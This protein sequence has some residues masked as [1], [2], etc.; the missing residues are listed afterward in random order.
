MELLR[1]WIY[2]AWF[3]L[4]LGWWKLRHSARDRAL[5]MIR[6]GVYY[7]LEMAHTI[8]RAKQGAMYAFGDSGIA[9][10]LDEII[11]KDVKARKRDS[12]E[13][14][15]DERL[16]FMVDGEVVTCPVE[17]TGMPMEDTEL[18]DFNRGDAVHQAMQSIQ[19]PAHGFAGN[20]KL[21][22]A[23][24]AIVII[25]FVI[26]KFVLHGHIPG[27]GVAPTPTPTPIPT[28]TPPSFVPVVAQWLN[29]FAMNV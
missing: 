28:P 7:D 19:G 10:A 25:G 29:W 21:F 5:I 17:G 26:Y 3:G 14:Y 9:Y 1:C 4:R 8:F 18:S 22:L 20:W 23:I 13:V 12:F 2:W 16:L 27:T 24:G 11:K 15:E 6:Q